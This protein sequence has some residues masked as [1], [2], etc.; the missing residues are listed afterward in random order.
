MPVCGTMSNWMPRNC[1]DI[2][3]AAPWLRS[4]TCSVTSCDM[5]PACSVT[6]CDMRPGGGEAGGGEGGGGDG[7]GDGA[8]DVGGPIAPF[9]KR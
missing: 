2:A 6:S 1:I 7:G 3:R 8:G 9:S 5:R 4:Y